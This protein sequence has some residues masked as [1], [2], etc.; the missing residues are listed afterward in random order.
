MSKHR[1]HS[2]R[3][4]MWTQASWWTNAQ[5]GDQ[6]AA[7]ERVVCDGSAAVRHAHHYPQCTQSIV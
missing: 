5:H 3:S 1:K 2:A 4:V 7:A 6:L